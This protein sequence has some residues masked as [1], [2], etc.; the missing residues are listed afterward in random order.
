MSKECLNDTF[1]I[2]DAV[3]ILYSFKSPYCLGTIKQWRG[4]RFN[5][6]RSE[7]EHRAYQD[8]I[9]HEWMRTFSKHSKRMS[10]KAFAI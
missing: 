2:G 3:L 8:K 1:R 5:S 10:K 7:S 4:W 9:V 6:I